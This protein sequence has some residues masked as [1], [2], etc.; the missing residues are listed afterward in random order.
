MKVLFIGGTGVISSACAQL[1]LEA[2]MELYLLNRGQSHRPQ[3]QGAQ[4]L[5]GDIRNLSQ[6]H[7]LLADLTFDVVVDWVAYQPEQVSADFQLFRNKTS[8]Y[9]FIS[10][11]SAY[12][13]PPTRL[14]ITENEPLVNP[15]WSYSQAK[16]ACEETCMNLY[17]SEQFPVTIVRPSHTYDCTKVPLMGGP[18]VLHRLVSG[19]PIIVHGDGTS[20]WTLTHHRDFAGGFIGLL[21]KEAAIGQAYHITSDEFLTWNQIT[22]ILASALGARADIVHV[23]SEFIH[24]LDPEWGAGLL[25]DKAHCMF[26][27]N[28]K[29]KALNPSFGA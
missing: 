12:R 21:G 4:H 23:P 28:S 14:P 9:I 16:I 3:P 7:S 8:Q 11:A 27:D 20:L 17:H 13:K 19:K 6:A 2:G 1:C 5:C 24:R 26:F 29:I 18:T 25:G 10:S 22:E 15:Y